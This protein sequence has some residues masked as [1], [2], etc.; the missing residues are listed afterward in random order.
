MDETTTTLQMLA[1]ML[2]PVISAVAVG[3]SQTIITALY[4]LG[5]SFQQTQENIPNTGGISGPAGPDLVSNLDQAIPPE[6][7]QFVVG[8]YL[9]QLLYILGIFYT[10]IT[11]GENQTI[12]NLTIGKIMISGLTFYTLGVTIVTLLFGNM[13]SGIL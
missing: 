2:A 8:I 7:L 9:I 5:Q 4:Q 12:K 3:M 13:V 6:A 1:Y 11:E 10:K